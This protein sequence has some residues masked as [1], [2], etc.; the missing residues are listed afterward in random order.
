MRVSCEWC[1][2]R[3]TYRIE[4]L[5]DGGVSYADLVCLNDATFMSERVEGYR[6]VPSK[7]RQRNNVITLFGS[8]E[9]HGKQ[10]KK[11]MLSVR[12]GLKDGVV[13]KR[14]EIRAQVN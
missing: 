6:A 13:K 4:S 12:Y 8:K 5:D 1:K 14:G 7:H 10:A 9:A 2:L 11:A 3:E